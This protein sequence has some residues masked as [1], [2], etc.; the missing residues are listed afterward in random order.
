AHGYP[1]YSWRETLC[2]FPGLLQFGAG[3]ELF[4]SRVV[5][6]PDLQLR[7]R[8]AAPGM[9]E[10]YVPIGMQPI[11]PAVWTAYLRSWFSTHLTEAGLTETTTPDG[12]MTPEMVQV[13]ISVACKVDQTLSQPELRAGANFTW[14]GGPTP[15][16]WA[17]ESKAKHKNML[18]AAPMLHKEVLDALQLRFPADMLALSAAA[19]RHAGER[20]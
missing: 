20:K 2:R 5:G 13:W 1:G 6:G 14:I 12:A 19:E 17:P 4:E 10:A 3:G 8:S 11:A 9:G 16:V 18:L 7:V 15:E